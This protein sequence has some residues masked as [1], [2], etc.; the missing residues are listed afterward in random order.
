LRGEGDPRLLRI[1]AAGARHETAP[2]A[3]VD[4]GK[5]HNRAKGNRRAIRQ[6][7]EQFLLPFLLA[8]ADK[9]WRVLG[10]GEDGDVL[11]QQF[12]AGIAELLFDLAAGCPDDAFRVSDNKS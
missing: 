9:P 10:P 8:N 4:H 1:N 5:G 12:I 7:D 2:L 6:F 11:A 3:S